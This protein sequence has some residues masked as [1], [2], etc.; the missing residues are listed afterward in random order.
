MRLLLKL[1]SQFKVLFLRYLKSFSLFVVS[2]GMAWHWY[3]MF[4]FLQVQ[5]SLLNSDSRR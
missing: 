1:Q 3:G 2:F 5:D 4:L